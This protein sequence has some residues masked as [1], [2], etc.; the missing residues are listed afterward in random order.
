MR[1]SWHSSV[2]R[3][4]LLLRPGNWLVLVLLSVVCQV[5]ECGERYLTTFDFALVGFYTV[6]NPH[7][8]LKV[9]L[10]GEG[11]QADL[12]FVGFLAS[13]GS[14]VDVE[15][16]LTGV[17]LVAKVTDERLLSCVYQHVRLQVALGLERFPASFKCANVVLRAKMLANMR[18][19][20]LDLVKLLEAL[21]EWAD[22][23]I[24]A[25]A[26]AAQH[27]VKCLVN[28]NPV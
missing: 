5:A 4:L 19:Q 14:L 24:V 2:F 12:A 22:E 9:P 13:V 16:A 28:R 1:L 23:L 6:V 8:Y 26:I 3:L 7:V 11:A 21:Q 25:G 15:S 27:L 18:F 10:L 17:T 20:S